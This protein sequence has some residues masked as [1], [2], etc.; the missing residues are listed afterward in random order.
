[1]VLVGVRFPH[2]LSMSITNIDELKQLD[3]TALREFVEGNKKNYEHYGLPV[4]ELENGVEYAIAYDE[5]EADQACYTYI[6]DSAWAFTP[7]F[8]AEMTEMPVEIF[9]A[10]VKANLCES[11]NDAVMACINTTCGL[12]EVVAC[13]IDADGRGH[14]LGVYDGEE[15]EL[16][17]SNA[18]AYQ[19]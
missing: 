9:E 15:I 11:A 14:F 3:E 8:L 17:N 18:Y 13:A 2:R 7:D 4:V 5:D 1:M 6:E 10:L 19:V 12:C 16:T